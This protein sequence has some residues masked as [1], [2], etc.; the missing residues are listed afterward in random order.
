[1]TIP[2]ARLLRALVIAAG[3]AVPALPGACSTPDATERSPGGV[4]TVPDTPG[5]LLEVSVRGESDVVRIYGEASD[6]GLVIDRIDLPTSDGTL[7]V[8]VDEAART[9]SATLGGF[10]L[11]LE[12]TASGDVAHY[13]MSQDG[14]LAHAGGPV[15]AA[16]WPGPGPTSARPA[17][18]HVQSQFT[19]KVAECMKGLVDLAFPAVLEPAQLLA[20]DCVRADP[21]IGHAL[22]STCTLREVLIAFSSDT[23]CQ[24]TIFEQECK[25]RLATAKELL[26]RYQNLLSLAA[27]DA[28]MQVAG[29]AM[30]NGRCPDAAS[31]GGIDAGTDSGT[32]ASDDAGPGSVGACNALGDLG[33]TA[34]LKSEAPG[35]YCTG[36][37]VFTNHGSRNIDVLY[38]IDETRPASPDKEKDGF[39]QASVA[40]GASL[41]TVTPA[42]SWQAG[43]STLTTRD[44]AAVYYDTTDTSCQWIIQDLTEDEINDCGI[45]VTDASSMNMCAGG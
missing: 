22:V 40:P 41:T 42:F 44:V 11:E 25:Q 3:L 39:W 32:D 13:T 35:N 30:A 16:S 19:D 37:L 17:S 12:W 45:P 5:V 6:A 23:H 29:N 15:A 26:T 18:S 43:G 38:Y 34:E 21:A 1:M 33:I 31:D 14:A 7:R 8:D 10:V 28:I 24:K 4:A 36:N 9:L 27:L 20:Y 2:G